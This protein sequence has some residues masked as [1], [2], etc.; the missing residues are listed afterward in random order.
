MTADTREALGDQRKACPEGS[1]EA[2]CVCVCG[3]SM[4]ERE[5]PGAKSQIGIK[6]QAKEQSLLLTEKQKGPF[7][8][9]VKIKVVPWSLESTSGNQIFKNTLKNYCEYLLHTG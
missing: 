6:K 3:G 1:G 9:P 5:R 4:E 7:S 2:V 8:G